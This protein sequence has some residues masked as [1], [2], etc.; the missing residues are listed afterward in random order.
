[1]VQ[2][3]TTA[4][5]Y[6]QNGWSHL[7]GFGPAYVTLCHRISA[8][9]A[10]AQDDATRNLG[11]RDVHRTQ[12]DPGRYRADVSVR[13]GGEAGVDKTF[14]AGEPAEGGTEL[15]LRVPFAEL[16]GLG[17]V[18]LTLSRHDGGRETRLLARN[19]PLREGELLRFT[20]SAFQRAYPAEAGERATF[21][22][23]AGGAGQ[24][25]SGG[26]LARMLAFALLAALL[27]ESLLAFRSS[28]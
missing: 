26:D 9:V 6:L 18:E 23:A 21:E 15:E 20:G 8:W 13:A 12:L 10:R 22:E 14:T 4:D 11:T 5:D 7:A 28:K 25:S 24:E 1:V 2:I 17:T 3:G 27:L 16:R 19:P